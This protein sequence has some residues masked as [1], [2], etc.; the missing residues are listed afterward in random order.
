MVAKNIVKCYNRTNNALLRLNKGG[1]VVENFF[2]KITKRKYRPKKQ[3]SERERTRDTVQKEDFLLKQIDEFKEKA[4]QLQG[5]L[6]SREDKVEEL[7]EIVQ[8]REEKAKQLQSVL[9]ER[10]IEADKLVKNVETQVN[11]AVQFF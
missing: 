9:E 8:E 1:W 4:R 6:S 5:L 3:E 7:Q 10:Q 2:K 11:A